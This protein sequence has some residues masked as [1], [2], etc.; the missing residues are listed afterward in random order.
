MVG[1]LETDKNLI[2]SGS[3]KG[4]AP[5]VSHSTTVTEKSPVR[6]A[7]VPLPK[8]AVIIPAF[9]EEKNIEKVLQEIERLRASHSHW[10][11]L[12]IVVNDGSSDRTEQV[13]EKIA[14]LYRAKAITLPL[15]LGIGRAVQTG[16][17]YAIR[18]GADVTLQLDV[19][20]QH[21]AEQI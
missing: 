12:P 6:L 9:N 21:P 5:I 10:E 18:W 1:E 3:R 17:K 16:F 19:D 15:N 2:M 11:I 13:L 14:P 8:I 20:G 7:P 4:L